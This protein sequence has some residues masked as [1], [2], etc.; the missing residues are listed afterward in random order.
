MDH[1][2]STIKGKTEYILIDEQLIV[3][4]QVLTHARMGFHDG[5]KAAIIIKGGPGTGKSVIA[6]N[7]MADLLLSKPAYNTYYATG[8][9]AFTETLRSK[10]GWRGA[11]QIKY[12]N[13]FTSAEPNAIDVI[14]CDEAHRIW[15]TNNNRFIRKDKRSGLKLVEEI[16]RATKVAVFFIDDKQI[17][18]PNEIGSVSYIK[19]FAEKY[20]CKIF[21][22]ELVIQFRCSGS[23]AFVNW[24]DNT[25][26]IQKT[27]NILWTKEESF[28]FRIFKSPEELEAA[29]KQKVNEGNTGRMTA[30]FCWKWS[31]PKSDGEL[32][33]DVVIG[34]YE[35]PWNAK[36]D[37]GHLATGIPKSH[38]WATN[39]NGINQVGCVYTAQGFEFDYVGVIIGKDLVY[40][41]EKQ[42][43][44]GDKK[45]SE[46][47]VVRGSKDKFTDLIKNSYRILLTRGLKGCYVYFMDKDT[48]RFVK[49]RIEN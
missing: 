47:T 39:P 27:A 18:R 17:V 49:S 26:G 36:P 44:Q 35:R 32:E 37:A 30:G 31:P 22:H 10:I 25:L 45:S 7:L 23:D 6:I 34:D 38:F 40:D 9:K 8:S 5:N 48:E 12:F 20:N 24:V 3:Y 21:E 4:D 33:N 42:E 28:D 19:E 16:L 41:F 43:W 29:I 15:E 14:I 46:D 1:V 11:T 13:S 2:G